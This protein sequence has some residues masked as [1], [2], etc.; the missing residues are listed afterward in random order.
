M[1][2][3]LSVFAYLFTGGNISPKG[4]VQRESASVM[5]ERQRETIIE[6]EDLEAAFRSVI[7]KPHMNVCVFLLPNK[8]A[9]G[10]CHFKKIFTGQ[11]IHYQN[12]MEKKPQSKLMSHCIICVY[13][14]K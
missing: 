10:A 9:S 13:F 11:R 4:M 1:C 8:S 14:H 5:L 6:K 7:H 12:D 2:V 3:C